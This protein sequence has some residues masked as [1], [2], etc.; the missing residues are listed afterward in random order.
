M[1]VSKESQGSSKNATSVAQEEQQ[2]NLNLIRNEK[3]L[4]ASVS[5]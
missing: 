1:S 3:R 4:G 5:R 2:V